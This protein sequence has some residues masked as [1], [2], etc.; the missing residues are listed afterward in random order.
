MTS[1][2]PH[3]ASPPAS[4]RSANPLVEPAASQTFIDHKEEVK[5]KKDK[6]KKSKAPP[7]NPFAAYRIKRT[8]RKKIG[9]QVRAYVSVGLS[10]GRY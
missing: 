2:R 7:Q 8:L 6:K 10:E 5:K 4:E 1:G 3:H 9:P